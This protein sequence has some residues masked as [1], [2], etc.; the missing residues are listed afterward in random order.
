[1]AVGLWAVRRIVQRECWFPGVWGVI[2][3]G[4]YQRLSGVRQAVD[5]PN[6]LAHTSFNIVLLSEPER[7]ERPH[8]KSV[9]SFPESKR[10]TSLAFSY[11]P[12][13]ITPRRVA[14]KNDHPASVS[15]CS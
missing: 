12:F 1:M 2:E 8:S 10:P 13:P 7:V 9:G 14:G 15:Q 11:S 3:S 6:H 4:V 5:D